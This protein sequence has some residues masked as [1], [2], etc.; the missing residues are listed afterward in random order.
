MQRMNELSITLVYEDL[1]YF[2]DSKLCSEKETKEY[3]KE[4][5]RIISEDDAKYLTFGS[6][7]D[8]HFF[9]RGVIE[10]AIITLTIRKVGS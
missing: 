4:I 1:S 7:D 6:G 8:T 9:S 3:I 10:N 5:K 2:S